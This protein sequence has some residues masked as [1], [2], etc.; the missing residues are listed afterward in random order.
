MENSYPFL[1][2][3]VLSTERI[4]LIENDKIINNDNGTAN[5]MH[6]I[7]S[8]IVISLNVLEY[9]DC[10]GMSGNDPI[11]KAKSYCRN[12]PSITA[13]NRV[14]NSYNLFSF[15]ISNK[16]KI[17]K[18]INSLD[19]T[20]TCQESDIPTKIIKEN[21]HIFSKICHFSFD[22]LVKEGTFPSIFKL[23]DVTPIFLKKV[24]RTL[25]IITDQSA[26]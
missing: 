22:A 24:Q 25:K 21:A 1:S 8:T 16:E 11:L 2:D 15:D 23:A 12:H 14:S 9:H 26:F 13:I 4:T 20:K 5:I 3:K 17:L 7:F 19:H 18:E 10:E 6:I